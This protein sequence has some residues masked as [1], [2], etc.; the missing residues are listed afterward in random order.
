MPKNHDFDYRC[1]LDYA[2]RM[3]INELPAK[4]DIVIYRESQG[5]SLLV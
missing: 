4:F 2:A 5:D 1:V 3:V